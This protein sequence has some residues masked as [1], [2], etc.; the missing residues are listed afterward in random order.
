MANI[1]IKPGGP[2]QQTGADATAIIATPDPN[3]FKPGK[4]TFSLVV[5]DGL[6]DSE[7]ATTVVE[8]R[9]RPVAR[10]TGKTPVSLG[11]EINLSGKDSAPGSADAPITTYT[12]TVTGPA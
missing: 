1:D 7:A 11:Q 9:A 6:S 5:S 8:V 12:W 4:Y 2:G 3:I 10:I